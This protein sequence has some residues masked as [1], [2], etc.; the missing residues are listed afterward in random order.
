MFLQMC[1]CAA[2]GYESTLLADQTY[3]D[4]DGGAPSSL[5]RRGRPDD[6]HRRPPRPD[7]YP[8]T[9][10]ID[11]STLCRHFL[12]A[13]NIRP[14]FFCKFQRQT[15]ARCRTRVSGTHSSITYTRAVHNITGTVAGRPPPDYSQVAYGGPVVG[16]QTL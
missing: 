15:A 1:P 6:R 2:V 12:A 11:V 3:E 5:T 7:A 9:D 4:R 14:D 16:F 10:P 13:Y 8:E